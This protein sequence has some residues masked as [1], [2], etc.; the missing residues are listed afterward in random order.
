MSLSPTV[1]ELEAVYEQEHGCKP[2]NLALRI[3][4]HILKVGDKLTK[5]G[6]KDAQQGESA[7]PVQCFQALAIKVFRM[8]DEDHETAQDI[9][10]LWRDYYM[11]GYEAGRVQS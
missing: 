3:A 11:D 4:E 6:W 1:A 2:G 7:P 8:D 10:E 9:A 5:L